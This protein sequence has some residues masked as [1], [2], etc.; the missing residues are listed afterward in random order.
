M[1]NY[2]NPNTFAIGNE[3]VVPIANKSLTQN[4][5][6]IKNFIL[7]KN[8]IFLSQKYDSFLQNFL[9]YGNINELHTI[10]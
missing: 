10:Q 6:R 8:I 2:T 1:S 3:Y 4:F 5:T 9:F 7:D